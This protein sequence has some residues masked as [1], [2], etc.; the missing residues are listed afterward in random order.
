MRLVRRWLTW[1][2]VAAVGVFGLSGLEAWPLTGW[3]L[4][5]ARRQPVLLRYEA[6]VVT[7]AGEAPV[8]F[9]SLPHGY[10]GSGPVLSRMA[11]QDPLARV[12]ACAAW[13]AAAAREL[14]AAV[15]E[16]R[17][18]AVEDDLRDGSR[19]DTLAWTCGR[20]AA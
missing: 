17:V 14:G 16:V 9:G 5:S 12:P 6:R 18:Y 19:H 11:G 2:L 4:F 7:A 8:P 20:A 13:A 1:A 15:T 10:S 3:R